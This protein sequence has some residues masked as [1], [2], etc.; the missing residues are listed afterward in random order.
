MLRRL[1]ANGDPISVRREILWKAVF[2]GNLISI[3]LSK[4]T[5]AIFNFSELEAAQVAD[6]F[7][8]EWP[9]YAKAI[10]RGKRHKRLRRRG[11]K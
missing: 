7:S 3:P 10:A 5:T 8:F 1:R 2:I 4:G 11:L 9:V 6:G